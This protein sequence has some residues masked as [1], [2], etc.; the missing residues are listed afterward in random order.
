VSLEVILSLRT[1]PKQLPS[2]ESHKIARA[3]QSRE[4]FQIKPLGPSSTLVEYQNHSGL[5]GRLMINF[6]IKAP[7]DSQSITEI[8]NFKS[9][10]LFAAS[11]EVSWSTEASCPEAESHNRWAKSDKLSQS[12][13]DL[14]RRKIYRRVD[15]PKV[16]FMCQV[17]PQPRS[18][19]C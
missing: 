9:V 13:D 4:D 1:R 7:D 10:Q 18:P 6:D 2:E 14:D 19:K 3:W 16:G 15:T 8:T 17:L 12:A 5:H 11:T